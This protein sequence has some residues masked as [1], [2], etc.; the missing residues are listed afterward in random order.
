VHHE[1]EPAQPDALNRDVSDRDTAPIREFAGEWMHGVDRQ[2]DRAG[3]CMYTNAPDERFIITSP[4]EMPGV[5]VVS[6]CSGHGFKFAS[7][8]G[9]LIA[10][11]LLDSR[12]VPPIIRTQ[13]GATA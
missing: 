3:V 10:D 11:M 13:L 5:T 7:A 12:P 4:H 2:I 8:I 6:A 1:G 9:D